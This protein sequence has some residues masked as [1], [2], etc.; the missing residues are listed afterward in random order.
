MLFETILILLCDPALII[1]PF[2]NAQDSNRPIVE[3]LQG[4]IQGKIETNSNGREYFSFSG[5]P[6]AKPPVGELRFERPQPGEKW[7]GI[8]DGSVEGPMCPQIDFFTYQPQYTEDCL[9]LNVY[10]PEEPRPSTEGGKAV[11]LDIHGG[12]YQGGSGSGSLVGMGK[13]MEHDVIVVTFNHRVNVFGF[14]A[15]DDDAAP[16]NYGLWDQVLAMEWVRDNIRAFGGDPNKVTIRG[17]SAGSSAVTFQLL[18]PHTKGLYIGAIAQSGSALDSWGVQEE[19]LKYAMILAKELGCPTEDTKGMV[20]SLKTKTTQEI[21]DAYMKVF[22][23]PALFPVR[24]SPVVEKSSTKRFL[25]DTP[26]NLLKQGKFNKVPLII[27]MTAEE[28][29]IFLQMRDAMNPIDTSTLLESKLEEHI[30]NISDFRSNLPA[31]TERIKHEY[32]DGVDKDD[33]EA[34]KQALTDVYSD[35]TWNAGTVEF[36]QQVSKHNVPVFMYIFKYLGKP[37]V[38]PGMPPQPPRKAT[39][40]GDDASFLLEGGFFGTSK[41]EGND[42][43]VSDNYLRLLTTFLKQGT[44]IQD[45][46]KPYHPDKGGYLIIDKE[47]STGNYFRQDKAKLWNYILPKIAAGQELGKDEL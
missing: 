28:G 25:P 20:K 18:T 21:L 40:H 44:T 6:F 15:T 46:W 47:L 11:M 23:S 36:V 45:E 41:L 3:T 33:T 13:F 16:G 26:M 2:I 22:Y 30:V 5:I 9:F 32:F 19:P 14:L 34:M 12:G 7:E 31:V 35:C 27:G 1:S 39:T 37:L 4:S 38:F 29:G 17:L 8:R 42:A 24:F 43:V 10:T